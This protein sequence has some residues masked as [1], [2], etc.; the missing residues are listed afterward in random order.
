MRQQLVASVR[1]GESITRTAERLLDQGDIVV[2]LPQHVQ[3]LRDAAR[4][5]ALTGDASIYERAV[6]KWQHRIERL[7]QAPDAAGARVGE[8]TVRSATQRLVEELR[9]ATE[10]QIDKIIDR[11]VLD[12]ARYQ[13]RVIARHETVE[14]YR[15]SYRESLRQTRGVVGLR[16]QVSG[17]H[18]HPDECDIY[19]NQD[20]HG[21]G[22][23]GYPI[24]AVPE[25]P[26]PMCLCTQVAIIDRYAAR[27]ELAQ[28]RGDPEPPRDWES[29]ERVTAAEWLAQQS[30]EYRREMLG[31]TR[32]RVFDEPGGPERVLTPDGRRVPVYQVLGQPRPVRQLGPEVRTQRLV[33]ED[34]A[35]MVRPFP[36]APRL[37]AGDSGRRR[38]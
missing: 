22:P 9:G 2:R 27:R 34:R 31:P 30:P 11:W 3:A 20:L 16:W 36:A 8:Y 24:D 38:R 25:A 4:D 10:E 37:A 21:L 35:S 7:G 1:A 13:A 14:A 18:P 32:A 26:H 19:A 17:R 12:R 6:R 15:E 23:G 5:A 28:M 29:G 33:R